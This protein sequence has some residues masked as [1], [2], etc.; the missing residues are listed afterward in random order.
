MYSDARPLTGRAVLGYTLAAFGAVIAANVT[1]AV[2]AV[3]TFPGLETA[4]SY[5]ASQEFEARAQAQRALGWTVRPVF[6]G[7]LVRIAITDRSGGPVF[8][9]QIALT[10]GRATEARDDVTV[11]LLPDGPAYAGRVDLAPGHWR[12]TVE[13]TAREG[14]QYRSRHDLWV[15]G[16]E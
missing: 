3:G 14:T 12:L 10:A 13:A 4:N 6:D 16:S 15:R 2:F 5:V 9:D 11:A 8:P 1:L 7:G